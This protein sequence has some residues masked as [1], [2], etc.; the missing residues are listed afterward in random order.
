MYYPPL[1]FAKFHFSR[2]LTSLL[3]DKQKSRH[4]QY[5]NGSKLLSH[6]PTRLSRLERLMGKC[7]WAV[8]KKK[9]SFSMAIG[10][11]EPMHECFPKHSRMGTAG[12]K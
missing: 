1:H 6:Q 3:Q 11:L 7:S 8:G 12:M 2:S 10:N 9:V 4:R 5:N